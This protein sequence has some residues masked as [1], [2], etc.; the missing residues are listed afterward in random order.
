M[1]IIKETFENTD[2][3]RAKQ[4]VSKHIMIADKGLEYA[5]RQILFD[6]STIIDWVKAEEIIRQN[7]PETK[8]EESSN[9]LEAVLGS[10]TPTQIAYIK[11]YW[12]A[13]YNEPEKYS[14]YADMIKETM[15]EKGIE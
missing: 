14:I 15:A 6:N 11:E 7:M 9:K 2:Q 12:N 10:L 5:I 4:F 1:K 8:L 3:M 13:F